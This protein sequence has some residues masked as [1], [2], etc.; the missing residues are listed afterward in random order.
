MINS[1]VAHNIDIPKIILVI[2]LKKAKMDSKFC[3]ALNET[4]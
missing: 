2:K 3:W 1:L 4:N